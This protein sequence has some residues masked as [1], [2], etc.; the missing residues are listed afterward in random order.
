MRSDQELGKEMKFCLL[1]G[2]IWSE[3]PLK[4]AQAWLL[5][6]GGGKPWLL[7]TLRPSGL[8]SI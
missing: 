3:R 5:E 8:S 7:P 1:V 2:I 6:L 4:P